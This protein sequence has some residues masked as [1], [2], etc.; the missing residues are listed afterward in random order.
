MANIYETERL[1]SE[2][3]LFHYGRAE[4]VL[5][6]A[7][8]P[9]D[10]LGYAERCVGELLDPDGLGP[11]ARALDVGCAVGRSTFELARYCG[12]AIGIDLSAAFIGAAEKIRREGVLAFRY[13][14]EGERMREGRAERPAGVEP[15]R[16]RFEVG[17]ATDLRD[18][19]GVFD[20]VLAANVL[21]RLSEPR[22]FLGRLPALV[23]PGGQLLLC[24]PFTWREEF[25]PRERWIGAR[26]GRESR[27]ELCRILDPHFTL[28]AARDLP[29]LIREHARKFQWSVAWASAWRRKCEV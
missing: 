2:Y 5:P 27:G 10:A 21:C 25:T 23:K 19:L 28:T 12:E 9:R 26:E 8:G 1:L 20:V 24:T 22:R 17:D 18:D 6:Y 4:D 16:V 13:P 14:V 3:L 29:F 15:A 11:P 7:F